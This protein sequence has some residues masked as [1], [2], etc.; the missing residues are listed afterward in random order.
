MEKVTVRIDD[1]N[2][3]SK[4]VASYFAQ[5]F[6]ALD[7]NP[8]RLSVTVISATPESKLVSIDFSNDGKIV[9][10]VGTEDSTIADFRSRWIAEHEVPFVFKRRKTRLFFH[11]AEGNRVKVGNATFL[12]RIIYN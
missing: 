6:S 12:A 10:S 4:D 8:R 2:P 5:I 1:K 7:E 3:S 9:F 11:P